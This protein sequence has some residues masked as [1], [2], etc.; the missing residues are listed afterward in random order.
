M[1]S[2][3]VEMKAA[4]WADRRAAR[5]VESMAGVKAAPSVDKKA[6]QLV[7]KKAAS[8][9]ASMVDLKVVLTVVLSAD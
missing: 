3:K 4:W 6:F 1:V 8:M 2:K 7:D 9:A 5:R